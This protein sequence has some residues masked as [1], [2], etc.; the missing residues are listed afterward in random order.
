M[1]TVKL[2]TGITRVIARSPRLHHH[3]P[4]GP[5]PPPRVARGTGGAGAGGGAGGAGASGGQSGPRWPHYETDP[6]PP[7]SQSVLG[8]V[9]L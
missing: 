6:Q 2:S 4:Q 8:E 1:V 3:L 5:R 9:S 7:E